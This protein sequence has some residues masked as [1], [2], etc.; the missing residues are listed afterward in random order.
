MK[1]GW[2]YIFVYYIIANNDYILIKLYY[3]GNI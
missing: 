2:E 1:F 3:Y